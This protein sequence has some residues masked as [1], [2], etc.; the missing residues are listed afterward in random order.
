M[1]MSHFFFIV[2]TTALLV[3]PVLADSIV[4]ETEDG[5]HY[6]SFQSDKP[7]SISGYNVQLNFSPGTEIQTLEPLLPYAGAVNIQNQKGYA[8]IVGFTT[9]TTAPKRL[10]TLSY[11]GTGNFEILVIELYDSDLKPVSVTNPQVVLPASPTATPTV[12]PYQPASGYISPAGTGVNTGQQGTP[13]ASTGVQPI[14]GVAVTSPPTTTAST[15]SQGSSSSTAG[16]MDTAA[17][18]TPLTSITP[19]ETGASTG[20]QKTPISTPAILG[21]LI[22]SLI[23][24]RTG[25]KPI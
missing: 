18:I 24:W 4:I 13:D 8:K 14:P 9:E 22:I 11:S 23:I 20:A 21:G 12:P 7:V 5:N 17:A 2:F 10:A 1:R 19:V 25:R 16:A 6:I 3:N 15:T